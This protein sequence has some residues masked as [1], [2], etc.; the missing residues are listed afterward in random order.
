MK[1]YCC[2]FDIAWEEKPANFDRV[3]RLLED[4]APAPGSLAILP[5][6]FATGFSMNVAGIA[7]DERGETAAF[8][9][10]LA[11][12]LGVFLIGGVVTRGAGGKGRNEALAFDPEGREVARYCKLHPF[13]YGGE[14]AHY[15]S[16]ERPVRFEAG[17]FR[18]TPFI[19]Y[20]LRFPEIFRSEARRGTQLFAVIADWPEA[21]ESHWATLLQARAIENQAY[22]M[23]VNRCGDDPKLS[24]SGRSLIVDPRGEILADAGRGEA[25]ISAE[26][27]PD[28]L[29]EYRR[30]FPALKDMRDERGVNSG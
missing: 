29:S 24:Y 18:V 14:T 11:K 22:V 12:D 1:G 8:L 16:G 2:Q 5:E 4:A 15:E 6:M 13:S 27:D 26:L 3:R 10:G 25:V 20:D 21:R 30:V 9:S 23:G 7:E 19:C 28:A 17:G